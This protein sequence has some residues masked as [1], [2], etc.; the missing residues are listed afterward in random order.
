MAL[1]P[2][3]SQ[4]DV[5]L[6][7]RK[8]FLISADMAHGV[9]PNYS[10][11]HESNHRPAFH[12]GPVIK[13]NVNQRYA[14]TAPTAFLFKEV[15]RS[16]NIPFQEFVVKNDSPCGTT[17]GPILSAKFGIRTIDI[18]LPQFSMHSIRETC[19]SDDVTHGCNYLKQYFA[20]FTAIDEKLVVDK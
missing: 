13:Y 8:S 15:A 12:G 20:A 3:A 6:G 1:S 4:E 14:T 9:H 19:A 11:R 7:F 10:G 5:R 16:S 17:I 18:G 2:E